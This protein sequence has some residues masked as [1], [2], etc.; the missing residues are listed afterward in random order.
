MENIGVDFNL[1]IFNYIEGF[2]D[3]FDEPKKKKAKNRASKLESI[4]STPQIQMP[5]TT[6]S[7]KK[8]ESPPEIK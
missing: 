4:P 6:L 1:D 8:E 7:Q 3:I 5:R 2:V